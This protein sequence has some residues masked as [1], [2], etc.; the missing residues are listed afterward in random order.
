MD[1]FQF[2]EEILSDRRRWYRS[3]VLG[4]KRGPRVLKSDVA[5]YYSLHRGAPVIS[6]QETAIAE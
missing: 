4:H 6:G 3:G 1:G 2:L 5:D